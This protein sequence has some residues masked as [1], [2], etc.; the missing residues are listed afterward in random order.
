MST[1]HRHHHNDA[2]RHADADLRNATGADESIAFY[3]GLLDGEVIALGTCHVLS[4][5]DT[6]RLLEQALAIVREE[7]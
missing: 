3:L 1:K 6:I 5:A 4:H 7:P 2:C